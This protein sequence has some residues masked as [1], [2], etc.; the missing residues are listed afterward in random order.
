ISNKVPFVADLKPSGK[1]VMEDLQ[2]VGG[3]PAVLKMLM[4][5]GLVDGSCMTVTG[6]TM[7]ENLAELPGLKEGQDII[8]PMSDPI[9]P[10]GHIQILYGN[11]APGGAVAKITGK[12]GLTFSGVA[13]V[14]VT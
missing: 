8:K 12:E 14:S 9:K 2:G 11:V 10:S 3:I 7:A 4:E 5:E 6:K 13:K 1:Y